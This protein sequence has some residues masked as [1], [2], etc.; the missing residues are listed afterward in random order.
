MEELLKRYNVQLLSN[1][2]ITEDRLNENTGSIEKTVIGY[3]PRLM[4]SLNKNEFVNVLCK[5]QIKG[6]MRDNVI[7]IG[8]LLSDHEML[9]PSNHKNIIN[10]A[11]LNDMKKNGNLLD[12]Y[13]DAYDIVICGDGPMTPVN[14]ILKEIFN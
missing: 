12:K 5:N 13:M 3:D 1:T 4:H 6:R 2:F 8:D 14:D 9:T 7:L 11:Y 10:I